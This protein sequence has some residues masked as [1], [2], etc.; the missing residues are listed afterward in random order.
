M[1]N[2]RPCILHFDSLGPLKSSKGRLGPLRHFLSG[3]WKEKKGTTKE[4]SISAMPDLFPKV[5]LQHNHS[6][7]GIFVLQYVE[8]F[9]KVSSFSTI[10]S[11]F[12]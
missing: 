11:D 2:F 4:F 10:Y 8:Q 5:P 9:L 1:L 7:C 12:C 3:E 6:D